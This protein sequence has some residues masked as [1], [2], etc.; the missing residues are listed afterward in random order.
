MLDY[1]SEITEVDKKYQIRCY[2]N[3]ITPSG[4]NRP[5]LILSSIFFDT[6]DEA[7][8]YILPKYPMMN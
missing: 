4:Y 2:S 5:I 8:K 1:W 7:L 3:K 6:Y